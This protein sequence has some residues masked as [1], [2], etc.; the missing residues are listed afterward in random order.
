M[1]RSSRHRQRQNERRVERER[2]DYD[3]A[4]GVFRVAAAR[5]LAHAERVGRL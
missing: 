4:V 1:T 5:A 2:R 3:I